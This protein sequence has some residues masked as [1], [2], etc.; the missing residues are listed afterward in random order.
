MDIHSSDKPVI[1]GE[2]SNPD[3][4]KNRFL[5]LLCKKFRHREALKAC[6]L[7]WGVVSQWIHRDKEFAQAY[8]HVRV[9]TDE[10][11]RILNLE[12][13]DQ[14]AMEGWTE[15]VYYRGR[16]VGY[17]RRYSAKKL[18]EQLRSH[19]PEKY[20]PEPPKCWGGGS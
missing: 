18:M 4:L 2:P 1:H 16:V 13:A 15:P 7:P 12:E 10:L 5:D 8:Y 19:D 17:I 20:G 11:A 6:R 14:K 3:G 9:S